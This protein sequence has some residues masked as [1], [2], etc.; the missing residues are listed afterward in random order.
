MEESQGGLR[1]SEFDMS[2]GYPFGDVHQ[3]GFE[4]G[5]RKREREILLCYM[6]GIRNKALRI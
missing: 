2:T 5:E 1:T 6:E 3:A 4:I